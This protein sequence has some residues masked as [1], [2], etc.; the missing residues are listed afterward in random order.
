M[1]QKVFSWWF[2]LLSSLLLCACAKEDVEPTVSIAKVAE[3]TTVNDIQ[4]VLGTTIAAQEEATTRMSR[5]NTQ[6]DGQ[7]RGIV[8]LKLYPFQYERAIRE[9]DVSLAT[10]IQFF[11][12][13]NYKDPVETPYLEVGTSYDKVTKFNSLFYA[14]NVPTDTR[15][16]LMYGHA[17]NGGINAATT[18]KFA[19]GS[20]KVEG[21]DGTDNI[22]T[23]SITFEPDKIYQT[24]R[25]DYTTYNNAVGIAT[26]MVSFMNTMANITLDDGTTKWYQAAANSDEADWFKQFIHGGLT[27][28]LGN[29]QL[30]T[31]LTSIYN[32]IPAGT[33]KTNFHAAALDKMNWDS[34]KSK[35]SAKSSNWGNFPQTGSLPSGLFVFKW[36]DA[37]HQFVVLNCNNTS[38]ETP[39]TALSPTIL[40]PEVLA[41]PAQLWYYG[42]STILSRNTELNEDEIDYIIK[43]KYTIPWKDIDFDETFNFNRAV[44]D[45]DT[46]VAA[47]RT[48]MNYGV[49]RLEANSRMTSVPLVHTQYDG[50]AEGIYKLPADALQL[51]GIMVTHQHKVG[52]DFQPVNYDFNVVYDNNIKNNR[53]NPAN[54]TLSDKIWDRNK[55]N[56]LTLPSYPNEEV[57]I[58]AE[59]V[60]L[61]N[62][63]FTGDYLPY[64]GMPIR[65]DHSEIYPNT[66]FY[67]VGKLDPAQL[68]A[69]NLNGNLPQAF[70]SDHYT[71]VLLKLSNFDGAYNYVPEVRSPSLI[72][73]LQVVFDWE[74]A[75]PTTIW[76]NENED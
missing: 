33:F 9:G 68:K 11:T 16:F 13:E 54:F 26:A 18:D 14:T 6:A 56:I 64:K 39:N 20:L 69:T 71:T 42:N 5:T 58:I 7:F 36:I 8:D 76:L 29:N 60:L 22:A 4:L 15:S 49:A 21:L 1:R 44:V 66:P 19:Y 50:F 48:P 24:G 43:D 17:P 10:D 31:L 53:P 61:D 75:D 40:E 37:E 25:T 41:F 72:L 38:M 27:F 63:K 62:D 45:E 23:T 3:V 73:G 65:N 35:Y 34:S 70:I 47:I 51:K 46:E 2:I 52:F 59:F 28:T 12:L 32:V 30:P 67:M 55:V 74:Q 57:Y